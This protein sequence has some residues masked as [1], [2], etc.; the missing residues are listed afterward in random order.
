M[1]EQKTL[2]SRIENFFYYYKWHTIFTLLAIFLIVTTIIQVRSR[3]DYDTTI[4]FLGSFGQEEA[5]MKQF[6]NNMEQVLTDANED[7]EVHVLPYFLLVSGDVMSAEQDSASAVRLQGMILTRETTVMILDQG[8]MTALAEG[9]ALEDLTPFY[10]EYG[11]ELTDH[12]YG[13]PI[14]EDN[15][16]FSMFFMSGKQYYIT[17]LAKG[18]EMDA[19]QTADYENAE[20]VLRMVIEGQM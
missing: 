16:V 8:A 20:K 9:G 17:R 18:T 1:E 7:G 10:E 3:I 4:T 13:I 2:K 5:T 6:Q 12:P 14:S 11:L 19:R 15:P